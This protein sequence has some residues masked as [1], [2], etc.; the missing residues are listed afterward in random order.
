MQCLRTEHHGT[1][2]IT[3]RQVIATPITY[4]QN[5]S[6]M[7]RDQRCSPAKRCYVLELN[8]LRQ[9]DYWMATELVENS[10]PEKVHIGPNVTEIASTGG[11]GRPITNRISERLTIEIVF[12]NIARI[13]SPVPPQ[14]SHF[15]G[16]N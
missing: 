7:S 9:L 8:G 14:I 1:I 16:P 10:L 3:Y 5:K 6:A 4:Q 15:A 12:A 11:S 13:A 2:E